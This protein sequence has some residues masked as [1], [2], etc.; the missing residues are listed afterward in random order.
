MR[1]HLRWWTVGRPYAKAQVWPHV[2]NRAEEQALKPGGSFR[3][4]AKDCPEMVVVPAGSFA[5]GSPA[6]EEDRHPQEGPQHE[7]TIKQFAVSKFE[8]TGDDLGGRVE[9][10]D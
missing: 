2:L 9:V 10:G 7:G 3:E 6:T 1:P 4:C 8:R 5:V